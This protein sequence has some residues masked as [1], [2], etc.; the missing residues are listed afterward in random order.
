MTPPAPTPPIPSAKDIARH[1]DRRRTRRKVVLWLLLI[2][3]VIAAVAFLTCGRGWGLGGSGKGDG[4]G[5]GSGKGFA[6]LPV[7]APPRRCA[8]F[9]AAEGI[10][11]DGKKVTRDEAVAACRLAGAGADVVVAGDT[12]RGDWDALKAALDAA[13]I[14]VFKREPEITPR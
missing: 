14:E 8:I 12:R 7:D 4:A 5:S 3:A 1:L 11:V 10:T 6:A 2:A 9:V 13:H